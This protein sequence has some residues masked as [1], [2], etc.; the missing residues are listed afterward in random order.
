MW[1]WTVVWN[2]LWSLLLCSSNFPPRF[3]LEL[4]GD[5]MPIPRKSNLPSAPEGHLASWSNGPL[6]FYWDFN[7]CTWIGILVFKTEAGSRKFRIEQDKD[8]FQKTRAITGKRNQ[9]NPTKSPFKIH[10]TGQ[11]QAEVL[12][13]RKQDSSK[14]Y[15]QAWSN[16]QDGCLQSL[17]PELW[18]WVQAKK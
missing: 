1:L 10:K 14:V 16:Q 8:Y 7:C 15:A 9:K 5:S 3:E 11:I 6:D 13:I 4:I 17:R 18:K 2:L 12:Q